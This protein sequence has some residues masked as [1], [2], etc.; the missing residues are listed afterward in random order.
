M[1]PSCITRHF[2]TDLGTNAAAFYR[3]LERGDMVI[4]TKDKEDQS[5]YAFE[6]IVENDLLRASVHSFS[7]R[8]E[9]FT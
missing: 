6:S 3:L 1:L 2:I 8:C 9:T 4:G 7:V 5:V